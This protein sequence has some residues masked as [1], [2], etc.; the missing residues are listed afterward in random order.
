MKVKITESELL[1]KAKDFA[2][3]LTNYNVIE[4]A[5]TQRTQIAKERIENHS[6]LRNV[7]LQRGV[8]LKFKK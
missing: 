4:K 8:N 5:L 2:N 3:E 6:A 7:L 1:I